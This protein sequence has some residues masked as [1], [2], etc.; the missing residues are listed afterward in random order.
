LSRA[1]RAE[2][3]P[4]PVAVSPPGRPRGGLRRQFG[5]RARIA[6]ELDANDYEMDVT[7]AYSVRHAVDCVE[8]DIGPVSIR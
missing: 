6:G 3:A 8:R 5:R 1:A 7:S 2:S 4:R